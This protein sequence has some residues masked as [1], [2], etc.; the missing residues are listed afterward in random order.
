MDAFAAFRQALE[1]L[2]AEI[3]QTQAVRAHAQ[4]QVEKC[5]QLLQELQA[6]YH[7]I[8][9]YVQRHEPPPLEEFRQEPTSSV[10]AGPVADGWD[11]NRV[12]AVARVLSE[13]SRPLSPGEIV[14]ALSQVGRSD[15]MKDVA[16]ALSHL[17]KRGRADNVSRGRWVYGKRPNE[18]VEVQDEVWLLQPEE[19]EEEEEETSI[20]TVTTT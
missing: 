9:S 18:V 8:E 10:A 5:D 2:Q 14:E 12:E 1:S 7:G 17:K 6:E 20:V 15:T 13:A 4:Q 19:E 16:A 11:I 3:E